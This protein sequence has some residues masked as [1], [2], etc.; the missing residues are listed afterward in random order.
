MR[1]TVGNDGRGR[2]VCDGGTL[3]WNELLAAGSADTGGECE[4][5][6]DANVCGFVGGHEFDGAQRGER[7]D[8]VRLPGAA[9][10]DEDPG[11]R[12]DELY[13]RLV[14]GDGRGGGAADGDVGHRNVGAMEANVTG[15]LRA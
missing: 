4:S 10:N 5:G 13:V 6:D 1:P 15:R 11:W 3:E 9:A 12:S 2:A 14:S 8:D 7:D